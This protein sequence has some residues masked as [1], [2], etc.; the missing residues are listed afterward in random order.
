MWK[1][2]VNADWLAMHE[3]KV[4]AEAVDEKEKM[5]MEDEEKSGGREKMGLS[6]M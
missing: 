4:T 1:V 2:L 6:S 3:G 5:A